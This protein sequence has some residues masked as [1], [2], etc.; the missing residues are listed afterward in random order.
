MSNYAIGIDI[1]GTRIKCGAVSLTGEVLTK[2]ILESNASAGMKSLVPTIIKQVKHIR[3][4]FGTPDGIGLG[5]SGVVHPEFGVVYLPG[6]F[7]GLQ[8]YD[9][10]PRLRKALGIP[11]IADNDGQLAMLAEHRFGAARNKKWAVSLTLG[12]GVGSGVLIDGR[13]VRDPHLTFGMQVGHCVLQNY[14]GK[15]CLTTA[16]GTGETLCSCTA[17][18][19]S[20]RDGLQRGIPSLLTKAYWK[21]AHA[22][23]FKAVIAGVRR[24]DKLCLD[25]FERW[26]D[27]VGCLLT[28]A[29]HAYAAQ[30]IVIGGG[31]AYAADLF[32][33]RLR[34]IISR[35]TFRYPPK[36]RI[37]IVA[38]ELKD[39]AG[40]LGAAAL[41][42]EKHT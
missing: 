33:P 24:K 3:N 7:K 1:G 11:V 4:R 22:I 13:L 14:G 26:S 6:K 16:R 34:R 8:G 18:A 36:R 40:V 15:L 32:L 21:N 12:T 19:L 29:V 37:R 20:V 31:G 27:N 10:V 2:A 41:A 5:L 25:E 38:S 28:T 17:L 35:E 39:M 23:D 30:L 42:W 9:I